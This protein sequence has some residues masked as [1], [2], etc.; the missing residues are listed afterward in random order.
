MI[1]KNWKC[2]GPMLFVLV[3]SFFLACPSVWGQISVDATTFKDQSSASKTIATPAFSTLSG[4]ELLLAFVS[5]DY[6]SGS[7]TTVTGISGAGLTWVLVIRTNVQSGTGEIWRAFAPAALSGATVTATLSQSVAASLT[8]MSFTGVDT[9]GTNGSG[10]IGATGTGSNRSAA[11]TATLTTPLWFW[12]WATIGTTPSP[13]IW[14]RGRAWFIS[15]L[16][17]W[18]THIGY[19]G[20][21]QRLP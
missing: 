15:I 17:Q 19:S 20:K 16:R 13:V 11:P 12:A 4:N 10:A 18:E 8:V 21:V 14:A 2:A 5:A 1:L 6:S 3:V 7:N 9:S